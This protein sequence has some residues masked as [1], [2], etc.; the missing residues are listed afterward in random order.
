MHLQ[1]AGDESLI[2]LFKW[3]AS[4]VRRGTWYFN[5]NLNRAKMIPSM[6][7]NGGSSRWEPT[8]FING[9]GV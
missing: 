2:E 7:P 5:C 1:I 6:D 9:R 3:N 4:Y 8:A